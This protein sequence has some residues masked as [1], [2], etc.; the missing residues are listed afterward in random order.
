MRACGFE[1]A[2]SLKPLDAVCILN[3]SSPTRA[4][5]EMRDQHSQVAPPELLRPNVAEYYKQE[6]PDGAIGQLKRGVAQS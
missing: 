6:A 4:A 3:V 1:K 2:S 5:V